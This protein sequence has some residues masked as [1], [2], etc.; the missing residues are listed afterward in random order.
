MKTREIA[1]GYRL[2]QWSQALQERKYSSPMPPILQMA[3][4]DSFIVTL[5]FLFS[6]VLRI[7]RLLAY[8]PNSTD[9]CNKIANYSKL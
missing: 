3:G 4:G 5:Y 1:T 9:I 6:Y 8:E 7:C 2:S